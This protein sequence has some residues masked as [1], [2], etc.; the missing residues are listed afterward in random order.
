MNYFC[1]EC[2]G[3]MRVV[4]EDEKDKKIKLKCTVCGYEKKISRIRNRT[5]TIAPTES[6]EELGEGVIQD[7]ELPKVSIDEDTIKEALD[8]LGGGD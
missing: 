8:L 4:G 6:E 2:G 1:P 5:T 3:I 7:R